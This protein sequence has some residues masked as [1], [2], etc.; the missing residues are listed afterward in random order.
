[1]RNHAVLRTLG[2]N[3]LPGA[4]F[5]YSNPGSYLFCAPNCQIYRFISLR[6]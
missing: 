3:G 5:W 2:I 6:S 1:M 4:I